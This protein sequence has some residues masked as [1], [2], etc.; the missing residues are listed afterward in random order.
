LQGQLSAAIHPAST[1]KA[2]LLGCVTAA[3]RVIS[4]G[5]VT[6]AAELLRTVDNKVETN[7][8]TY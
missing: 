7:I 8:L 3:A 5:R 2:L 6:A 1:L 4:L